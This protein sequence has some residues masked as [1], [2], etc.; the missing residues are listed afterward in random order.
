MAAE[1]LARGWDVV[2]TVRGRA[3]TGLHDLAEHHIGRVEIESLDIAEPDE[4]ASLHDHRS[5]RR[6][7]IL[8]VN[9]GVA[10]S[11]PEEALG[12]VETHEFVRVMITNALGPM[13]VIEGLQDL[14]SPTGTIGVMSSGQGSI[15]NN[16]W[17]GND[18]YRAA[19]A[20]LNMSMRGYAARHA[21]SARSLVLL[22]PGW[23]RTDLGGPNATFTVEDSMPRVMDVLLSRQGKPC[24]C[25][26]D[27]E[28]R[29]VP[30]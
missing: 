19:K 16:E 26:L 20:A 23:V 21:E 5:G 9:A 22:A 6:F 30:W 4:I 7:D 12:L 15:A 24:L 25:D 17:G 1:F 14:V 29:T 27:R 2:G 28:G 3:R 10:N 13:R 11:K 18:V 8:F